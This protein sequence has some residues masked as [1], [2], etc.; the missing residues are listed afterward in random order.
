[1]VF[2]EQD[3]FW[4]VLE[5]G[6]EPFSK[7]PCLGIDG[8]NCHPFCHWDVVVVCLSFSSSIGCIVAL[9]ILESYDV[10]IGFVG[11]DL[12]YANFHPFGS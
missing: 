10:N 1:M 6:N 5:N 2:S 11:F 7:H 4:H 9:L 8:L 12:D 3:P